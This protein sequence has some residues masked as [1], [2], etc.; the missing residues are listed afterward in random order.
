MVPAVSA[1]GAGGLWSDWL[2]RRCGGLR[3]ACA[4]GS[5][6]AVVSRR[7][8]LGLL[9]D[10]WLPGMTATRTRRPSVAQVRNSTS[11]DRVVMER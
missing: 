11:N 2:A 9:F 7:S 1:D 5:V 4:Y 3:R 8:R 6:S 10:G